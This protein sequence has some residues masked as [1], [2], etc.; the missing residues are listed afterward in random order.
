MWLEEFSPTIRI[1]KE[2]FYAP[3]SIKCNE[4]R[5][6]IKWSRSLFLPS[7]HS[8]AAE[9][10]SQQNNNQIQL[11]FIP[12]LAEKGRNV[13]SKGREEI[14]EAKKY[15]SHVTPK[16]QILID[17]ILHITPTSLSPISIRVT[18]DTDYLFMLQDIHQRKSRP[19]VLLIPT[20]LSKIC[21]G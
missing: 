9:I 6:D 11:H 7:F 8:Q 21:T 12:H 10:S 5:L 1:E 14:G 3:C 20:S 2:T 13:K 15:K 4:I 18:I 17:D 16:I 19:N